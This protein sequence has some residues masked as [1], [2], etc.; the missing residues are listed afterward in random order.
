MS[1]QGVSLEEERVELTNGKDVIGYIEYDY[2]CE[3]TNLRVSAKH[4]RQGHGTTLFHEAL[5]GLNMCKEVK[6]LAFVSSIPFYTSQG[7]K[8]TKQGE[9]FAEMKIQN[10]Y[11][12]SQEK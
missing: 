12:N 1:Y 8:I 9:K 6:W 7:A 11:H 5:R 3:I 4:Q 10:P 2:A